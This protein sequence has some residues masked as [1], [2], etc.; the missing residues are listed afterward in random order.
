MDA[1]DASVG[2]AK[3]RERLGGSGGGGPWRVWPGCLTWGLRLRERLL[4]SRLDLAMAFKTFECV[5]SEGFAMGRGL[6]AAWRVL[7]G[8]WLLCMAGFLGRAPACKG[9]GAG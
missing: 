5:L 2:F 7:G 9:V 3:S 4:A 8:G 6:F 1:Q